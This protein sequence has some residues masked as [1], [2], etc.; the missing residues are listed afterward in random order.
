[1][2]NNSRH[3]RPRLG[4]LLLLDT[5]CPGSWN[6]A[7]TR[8]VRILSLPLAREKVQEHPARQIAG[9]CDPDQ[10]QCPR[11]T[12]IDT[13]ELRV[14]NEKVPYQR[15]IGAPN[16]S[17]A[18]WSANQL[19]IANERDEAIFSLTS[20]V[21][22]LVSGSASFVTLIALHLDLFFGISALFFYPE[23]VVPTSCIF[24]YCNRR[25]S[26]R[27]LWLEIKNWATKSNNIEFTVDQWILWRI[28]RGEFTVDTK[29]LVKYLWTIVTSLDPAR[30]IGLKYYDSF[31]W[32]ILRHR[33]T[34]V[35]PR[36]ECHFIDIIF[37]FRLVVQPPLDLLVTGSSV[38]G[39]RTCSPE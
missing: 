7:A 39:P 31:G 15:Y 25:F 36:M 26:N 27:V 24:R 28:A 30:E 21:R 11:W 4:L 37:P 17:Q 10:W 13:D 19:C 35:S 32:S 16:Y 33:N 6:R 3:L 38:I 18:L 9:Y 20:F 14:E 8:F 5:E 12:F 29:Q 2:K 1:M 34:E 22:H 23:D